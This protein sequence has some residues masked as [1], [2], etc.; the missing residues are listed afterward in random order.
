MDSALLALMQNDQRAADPL[1]PSLTT[2]K[3]DLGLCCACKSFC[4]DGDFMQKGGRSESGIDSLQELVRD[5]ATQYEYDGEC[6]V[7]CHSDTHTRVTSA[8]GVSS[9]DT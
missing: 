3:V 9:L 4:M 6:A 1:S 7:L 2:N 8:Y 5:D